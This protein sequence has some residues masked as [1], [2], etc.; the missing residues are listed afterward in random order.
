MRKLFILLLATL[1]TLALAACD[2]IPT[3]ENHDTD[4]P[5]ATSPAYIWTIS[6]DDSQSQTYGEGQLTATYTVHLSASMEG[7][8]SPLGEY[9]G[10]LRVD[11]S[12]QPDEATLFAIEFLQGSYDFDGW[13]ENDAFS[14]TLV[15]Y[16]QEQ[17]MQYVAGAYQGEGARTAPLLTGIAMY[18]AEDIPWT[19]SDWGMSL[20]AGLTGVFGV[21]AEGDETGASSQ[22]YTPF[23]NDAAAS[24]G[25]APLRCT[26]HLI[27]EGR[28]QLN[29]WSHGNVDVNLSFN[30]TID[31]IPIEDTVKVN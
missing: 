17:L 8:D 15:P 14:F 5:E 22:V 16:D 18:A 9:Q 12:G 28:A 29:I 6:I 27:D 26:I 10:E 23:G 3:L 4:Q 2:D 25:G 21:D 7:G 20:N 13:G 30:G 11:Y 24:S 31:K 1:L 19:D